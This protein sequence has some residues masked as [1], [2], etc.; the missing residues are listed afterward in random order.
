MGV[1]SHTQHGMHV[2][3][4]Q[5]T[6]SW[7]SKRLKDVCGNCPVFFIRPCDMFSFDW[8]QRGVGDWAALIALLGLSVE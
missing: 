6:P 7:L 2:A 5:F 4:L 1:S 8:L 3:H